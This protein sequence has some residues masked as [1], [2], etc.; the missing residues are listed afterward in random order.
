MSKF[1][2]RIIRE[3]SKLKKKHRAIIVAHNY[4]L[5]EVQDIAD[6]CGDSLELSRIAAGTKARVVVFCGVHFMAETAS[7]LC[8]DKKILMPDLNSG[9]P[10]ADM[11]TVRDLMALKHKHPR[12]IVVGYVNTSAAVKAE[13]D[14][15]CTSANAVSVVKA[16][17]NDFPKAGS[18]EIIF[19]PD[20]N[21]A[22]FVSHRTGRKL[23]AWDG[24]CPIH[25]RILPADIKRVKKF[26]P[27]A[28]V[29]VHPECL[30]EVI[31]LS[32]AALSTSQMCKFAKTNKAKEFIIG[33]E[34][35]L[36]Y[37][38]KKN[39]PGK[40]FYPATQKALCSDMKRARLSNILTALEELRFEVR[41]KES[42]RRKAK[43][44]IER[45]LK[46]I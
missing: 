5:P 8:P 43:K 34:A 38:L 21:L 7:I 1:E 23:I 11:I 9:C 19:V 32:A 18:R 2:N 10:M 40:E 17:S 31:S 35:G 22:D 45:M 37:V 16:I 20:K 42:I 46:I 14:I 26:H 4:Q 41:V 33:T 29:I 25:A 3:I 36:I 15:C 28:S 12:A 6:Y 30:P 13:L 44:A 27:R 39:N 24:F